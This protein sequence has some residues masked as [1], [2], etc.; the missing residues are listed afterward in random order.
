MVK[1]TTIDQHHIHN[2]SDQS[3]LECGIRIGDVLLDRLE[4]T[5][6]YFC[7]PKKKSPAFGNEIRFFNVAV[8]HCGKNHH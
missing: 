4:G 7:D 5:E 2:N 3:K 8:A 1:L 6:A